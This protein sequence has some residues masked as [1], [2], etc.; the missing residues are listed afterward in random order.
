MPV[1][2]A[3]TVTYKVSPWPTSSGDVKLA[4]V[5]DLPSYVYVHAWGGKPERPRLHCT[6]LNT[7]STLHNGIDRTPY[8]HVDQDLHQVSTW[9]LRTRTSHDTLAQVFSAFYPVHAQCGESNS[10]SHM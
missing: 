3:T 1:P 7:Y 6:V 10:Y 9:H 2:L 8:M 4:S 5:P